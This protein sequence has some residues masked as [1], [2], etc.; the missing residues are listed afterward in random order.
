M[1]VNGESSPNPLT[2]Q[3]KLPPGVFGRGVSDA[4]TCDIEIPMRPQDGTVTL[5]F[6]IN[7]LTG[8]DPAAIASELWFL[9]SLSHAAEI[10]V[11]NRFG[12]LADGGIPVPDGQP[13][14]IDERLLHLVDDMALVQREVAGGLRLPDMEDGIGSADVKSIR[15]AATLLRG[16]R[17]R[18]NYTEQEFTLP[19]VDRDRLRDNVGVPMMIEIVGAWHTEILG[20]NVTIQPIDMG[21][22]SAVIE[23]D[24]EREVFVARPAEFSDELLI[25]RHVE[26]DDQ[27]DTGDAVEA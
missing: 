3:A 18:T 26:P 19:E 14:I 6:K 20:C 8:R 27:P 21:L 12:P 2:G 15:I 7:P 25:Q 22:R 13:A 16:G 24:E 23:L 5:R 1:W 11:G 4:N 10:R 9:N 17:V